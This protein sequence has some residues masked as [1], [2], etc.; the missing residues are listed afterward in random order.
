M[1]KNLLALLSLGVMA[2]FAA[3]AVADDDHDGH[4]RQQRV[5]RAKLIGFNEVPSV[6]SAAEG[7]FYAVVNKEGTSFTYWLSYSGLAFDAAQ[8]HIHFGQHHV[9]GGISVWLCQGTVPAPAA[10]AAQTPTCAT[11]ATTTP[12]TGTIDAS[13]VIGPAGQGISATEFAELLAAMR[14]GAAY[15]NVHSGVAGNPT[16]MP[17]TPTVGF[18]GGEI[19]G[20]VN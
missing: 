8:S 3:S 9:N 10:V 16:A 1:K 14:G 4:G 11:R 18:P 5:F 6:S 7:Q 20:Q 12:I 19:R 17:P 15:A 2:G 13:D